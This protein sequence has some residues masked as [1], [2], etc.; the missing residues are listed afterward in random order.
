MRTITIASQKGGVGK[1]TTAANLAAAWA[2]AGLRVLAID[3]D[4]AFALTRMFGQRPSGLPSTFRDVLTG[5]VE[6]AAATARIADRLDLLGGSRELAGVELA[7]VSEIGRE[8]FL[9]RALDGV[10]YDMVVIDT[11][12][13]LGLLTVN[14]LWAADEVV[15]PVSMVDPGA[16]QGVGELR[17]SVARCAERGAHVRLSGAVRT[18]MDQRR[19]VARLIDDALTE[20]GVP[21]AAATIPLRADFGGAAA[22]GWPL[23]WRQPDS[24]GATAY[25]AVAAEMQASLQEASP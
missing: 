11:P 3:A 4:P 15:A 18:M 20:L 2:D 8:T 9:Q 5:D 10:S 22:A 21:V 16:L 25:R 7:L 24:V 17:A 13:N 19:L 14:A 23:V 1:T 12:P 6:V